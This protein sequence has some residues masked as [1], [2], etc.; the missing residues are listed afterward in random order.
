MMRDFVAT[1]RLESQGVVAAGYAEL[2]AIM[3]RG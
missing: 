2:N 1:G 3:H